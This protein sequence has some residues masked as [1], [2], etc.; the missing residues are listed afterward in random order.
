MQRRGLRL[1]LN[2]EIGTDLSMR[3]L[4]Q[5]YHAVAAAGARQ[6][7]ALGVS[8]E[9]LAGSHSATDFVAWYNGHP[10]FA[11]RSYDLSGATP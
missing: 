5:R 11:D 2:T 3:D 4:A 9:D 1:F 7:R 6:D 8:G 10:D